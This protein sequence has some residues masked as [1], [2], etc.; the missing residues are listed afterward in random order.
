MIQQL[1]EIDHALIIRII[2][3]GQHIIRCTRHTVQYTIL[4]SILYTHRTH[5]K[6]TAT[7]SMYQFI[8]TNMIPSYRTINRITQLIVYGLKNLGEQMEIE[9]DMTIYTSSSSS[10]YQ[11]HIHYYHFIVRTNIIIYDNQQQQQ[12]GNERGKEYY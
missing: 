6:A 4:I 1:Q 2:L 7:S 3:I 12:E 9:T 10:S 8:H 5:G 11:S